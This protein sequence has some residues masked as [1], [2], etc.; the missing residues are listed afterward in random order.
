VSGNRERK[1]DLF[2]NSEFIRLLRCYFKRVKVEAERF[3]EGLDR[4]EKT[5]HSDGKTYFFCKI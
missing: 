1:I 5:I 3:R 4:F 2:S